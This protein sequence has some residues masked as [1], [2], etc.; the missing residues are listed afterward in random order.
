MTVSTQPRAGLAAWVGLALLTIP[1]FMTA[2]DMTVLFLAT[3]TIAAALEPTVTE[4]LWM[5]HIGEMVGAGL[6]LT[7]GRVVDRFGPRR[8]LVLS[9]LAYGI[10]NLLAAYAPSI[11]MLVA[12]RALI[13]FAAVSM[14]PSAMALLRRMFQSDQQFSVAV[15]IFMAAFSGGVAFGPPIGGVLLEHFWW[16][17]IFL[18]NVPIVLLVVAMATWL[19]PKVTG[20]GTSGVDVPSVLSSLGAVALVVYGAQEWAAG[21]LDWLAVAY[22]TIGLGLGIVF[23]R[24]QR[25]LP[26]PLLDLSLFR[27]RGFT[28]GLLAVLLVITVTAGADLQFAQHLQVVFD[29]TPLQ[30]GLLLTIPAVVSLIATVVA[31]WFLRWAQPSTVMGVGVLIAIAGAALMAILLSRESQTPLSPALVAASLITAGIAPIFA[32]GINVIISSAPVGQTGSASASGDVA[33]SLGN[34]LGLAVGGSIAFLS[35]QRA[36]RPLLPEAVDPAAGEQSLQSIGSALAIAGSLPDDVGAAFRAAAIE[37]FTIATR[38][39]YV[40]AAFG[41]A[42]L[43]V[44]VTW[45]LR[46]ARIGMTAAHVEEQDSANV[47]A[48]IAG[49]DATSPAPVGPDPTDPAPGGPHPDGP[50]TSGPDLVGPDSAVP[51]PAAPGPAVPD[52]AGADLPGTDLPGQVLPDA[53]GETR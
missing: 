31:P 36:L 49:P 20:T 2:I 34:T 18:V 43:A 33:G 45:G 15:A 23:V 50:H 25:Q 37:S 29:R 53:T 44:L 14:T 40:F 8:L 27:S 21:G 6:L 35:Y 28:V 26:T 17:S 19:L 5:L 7:A 32:L 1:V 3:P 52:L 24:R 12:A 16:G 11:E 47:P 46:R 4:Q 13:G 30:A 41:L 48:D 51:D 22:L 39:T 9:T 38:D 10:A 42:A